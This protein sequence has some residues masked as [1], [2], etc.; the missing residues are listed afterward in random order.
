MCFSESKEIILTTIQ[1]DKATSMYK[2]VMYVI[3][4]S[5][6]NKLKIHA[7]VP[8]QSKY[9]ETVGKWDE[10]IMYSTTLTVFISSDNPWS[11]MIR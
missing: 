6:K 1:I 3:F 9:N 11:A 2:F 8:S 5:H 7:A 4:P 10:V